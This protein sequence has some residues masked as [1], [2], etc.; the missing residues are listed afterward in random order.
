M[1]LACSALKKSYREL[2]LSS[3]SS[4]DRHA[5]A[6]VRLLDAS[7]PQLA[8]QDEGQCSTHHD[9]LCIT[10]VRSGL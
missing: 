7:V 9:L 8:L 10:M 1:V 6:V 4:P 5:V 3:D 2:L